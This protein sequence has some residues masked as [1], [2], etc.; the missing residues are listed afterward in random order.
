[1]NTFTDRVVL[2][3]GAGSGIGRQLARMLAQEGARIAA[4]DRQPALLEDLKKDLAGKPLACAVADVTDLEAVRK[5]VDQL[6]QEVGPT[7]LLI[8]S[9][10]LGHGTPAYDF[11]AESINDLIRVNLIG[12]VNSIDAVL[13]GM[14]RRRQGHLVALSS[15]ASYRGMP[16][17]A[18]Y[19]ASKAG[20]NALFDSLRVE[21]RRFGIAVTTVC[22]G[23]IR[24]P[25]TQA[26]KVPVTRMMSIEEAGQRILAAIRARRAFLAFPSGLVWQV[27]LLRYL[28]RRLADWLAGRYLAQAERALRA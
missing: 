22:P 8:A 27:R 6:E 24:T 9:A 12:V 3:T 21:L 25:M 28:P 7:D 20:L 15:L 19:S 18:G 14:R 13:P 26:L 5:A 17:M 1:M 2:I 23:W 10:G 4:L 11:Q 16:L